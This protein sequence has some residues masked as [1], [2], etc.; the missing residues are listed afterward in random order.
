[1][2]IACT[3]RRKNRNDDFIVSLKRLRR[4]GRRSHKGARTE[5]SSGYCLHKKRGRHGSSWRRYLLGLVRG[6][7][8]RP[9]AT[10]AGAPKVPLPRERHMV[11][12]GGGVNHRTHFDDGGLLR[13][14]KHRAIFGEHR[15]T[16]G[17]RKLLCGGRGGLYG[18]HGDG[19]RKIGG[20]RHYGD[21]VYRS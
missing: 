13:P 9:V 15:G 18:S 16:G 4:N 17:E 6:G 3:Q 2:D 21:Q 10:S 20:T 5:R 11:G 14:G 7:S 8:K 1:M 19:K 12:F